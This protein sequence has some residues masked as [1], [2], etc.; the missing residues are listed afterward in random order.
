MGQ[1]L[2]TWR[3]GSLWLCPRKG[4]C[5]VVTGNDGGLGD[6]VETQALL[7]TGCVTLSHKASLGLTSLICDDGRLNSTDA[8][9]VSAESS[10]QP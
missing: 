7:E 6:P 8:C 2:K 4:L 5:G 10:T 3:L 9:V 1:W